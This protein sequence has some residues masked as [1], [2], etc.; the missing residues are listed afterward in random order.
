MDGLECS[1]INLSALERTHRIDAEFYKK[2]NLHISARLEKK[3]LQPF[4]DSFFVSDGNHM[5]ISDSFGNKGVPYYRG[6]DIYNVFIEESSP[7]YIDERT[8]NFPHMSRSHLKYGDVLLSIV[9]TV[10]KSAIVY[11][12]TEATCSC[13]LAIIR[14]KHKDINSETL[15]VFIK[16][17]H[18]QNQIQKF[19]RGAVQTGLLL[20]DFDQLF[21]PVFSN[22]F[23]EKIKEIIQHAHKTIISADSEYDVAQNLLLNKLNLDFSNISSKG[24]TEKSLSESFGSTGR[25]DAEYYQPK[26]DDLFAVLGKLHTKPLGKIVNI[27]KSIEPGSEYYGDSGIPFVRVSD[28]NVMGIDSPSIKIPKTT[29][30][31]IETLYPKKDTILFSKDGSVGIAYKMEEDIEAVTSGALLHFRV[32]NTKEVLPDY[33]TLVLN[34]EVVQLQAERDS[35]GAIIQHWKPSDIEKVV[36]PI[37]SLDV[38]HEISEKVQ[39]SFSLRRQAESLIKT[40]IRAVEIAIESDETTALK[41]IEETLRDLEEH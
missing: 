21:V 26:Y 7:I 18:G 6:Q 20:E 27:M 5:S 37:L 33:L 28:V 16:T 41:W 32:K 14:S 24:T 23:Q 11:S 30:P 19:K 25:L 39:E 8:F 35:S 38:Q 12:D 2:T 13:K 10:G 40:A 29:V 34:S 36:I 9:G 1:E 3:I 31:S 4:T 17:E 22:Y 15:M